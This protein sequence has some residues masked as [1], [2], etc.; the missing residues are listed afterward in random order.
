MEIIVKDLKK[1]YGNQ[2]VLENISF[3][4]QSGEVCGLVGIN[5]AG[6]STLM[7]ILIG[8]IKKTSGEILVDGKIWTT[9]NLEKIGAIIE[10]PP[11]YGNLNAFDNLKAKALLNNIDDDRILEVLQMVGLQNNKKRVS[12]FSMGMKMRLGIGLAIINN[13][14]FLILDEP[15]NG[16]DPLGI[17]EL[18]N[19]ILLLAKK[20]TTVLVSS[21]Q[22]KDVSE[23]SDH[24]VMIN[25]GKI[26]YDGICESTEKLEKEFFNIVNG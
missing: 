15:T 24:I 1:E 6:K 20:G 22:L 16:L 7:K 18:K 3:K 17:K 13:P 14:S 10:S 8:I 2:I 25:K 5:G 26:A 4:I 12:K 21:H 11:L 23:I 9:N 19:L